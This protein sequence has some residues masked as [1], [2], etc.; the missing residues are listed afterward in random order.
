MRLAV[1]AILMA[2]CHVIDDYMLQGCLADL[3]QRDWWRRMIAST[4]K[5]DLEDTMYRRD[6]IAA[7]LCHGLSWSCCVHLPLLLAGL[8]GHPGYIACSVP[9]HALLHA[10]VDHAKANARLISLVEDRLLHVLQLSAIL[11]GYRLLTSL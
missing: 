6:Y 4:M 9:A 11:V 1:I 8:W 3:K 2:W 10:L 5:A 7:L